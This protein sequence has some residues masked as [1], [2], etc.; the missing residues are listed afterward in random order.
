MVKTRRYMQV[1]YRNGQPMAAYL[2]LSGWP[3][4]KSAR[5]ELVDAGLVVDFSESDEPLGLEIVD[6]ESVS[7]REIDDV[8]RGIDEDP[9]D[10]GEVDALKRPGKREG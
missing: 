4:H 5:T 9:L 2:Y 7:I 6:P 8:L 1:S 3:G 10:P